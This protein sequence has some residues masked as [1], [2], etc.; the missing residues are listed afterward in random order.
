MNLCFINPSEMKI[1]DIRIGWA[2]LQKIYC[3]HTAP[4]NKIGARAT[5]T[6]GKQ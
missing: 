3:N 1:G 6:N 5:T 2:F 4:S